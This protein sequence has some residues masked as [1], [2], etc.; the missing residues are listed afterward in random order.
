MFS[1]EGWRPWEIA[2][3]FGITGMLILGD[4]D[5]SHLNCTAQPHLALA[6]P[7]SLPVVLLNQ[8]EKITA[9]LLFISC[10]PQGKVRSGQSTPVGAATRHDSFSDNKNS[11]DG[12]GPE[13]RH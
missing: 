2:F 5:S 10:I 4:L 3:L 13:Y 11:S 1:K 9:R 7:L 6:V 8:K 12:F